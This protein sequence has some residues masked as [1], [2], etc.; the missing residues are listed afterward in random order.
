MKPFALFLSA[1]W[2]SGCSGS[3]VVEVRQEDARSEDVAATV[4][5]DSQTSIP[6]GLDAR[7]TEL[8][9]SN[10][11]E[12]SRWTGYAQ[13]YARGEKSSADHL[14]NVWE[15]THDRFPDD[16]EVQREV[17]HAL[18]LV[19]RSSEALTR[20]NA[21]ELEQLDPMELADLFLEAGAYKQAAAEDLPKTLC[22]MPR[23]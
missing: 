23:S 16:T 22:A 17:A 7:W 11:P 1:L 20:L 14:V 18:R 4:S 19:G 10:P 6:S 15:K 8:L 9:E 3:R 21:E 2:L 12:L 13:A 5:K